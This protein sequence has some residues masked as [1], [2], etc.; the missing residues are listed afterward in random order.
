[1]FLK[2]INNMK[3]KTEILNIRVSKELKNYLDFICKTSED[4]ISI[5]EY[6][7][8][9]GGMEFSLKQVNKDLETGFNDLKKRN[10]NRSEIK[11]IVVSAKNEM[12]K[13]DNFIKQLEIKKQNINSKIDEIIAFTH[14]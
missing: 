13:V 1:M 9:I 14:R 5:S 7:R 8:R 4:K 11:V 10:I 6:L 12:E 2:G 3:A